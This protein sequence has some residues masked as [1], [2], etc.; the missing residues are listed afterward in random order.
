MYQ[1]VSTELA[2]FPQLSDAPLQS[3]LPPVAGLAV[4]VTH[5]QIYL[6]NHIFSH[7]FPSLTQDT[8]GVVGKLLLCAWQPPEL[9][10][11]GLGRQH[12]ESTGHEDT[13]PRAA[14][15]VLQNTEA[16]VS[17]TQP[18]V[19]SLCRGLSCQDKVLL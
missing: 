3:S 9:E 15:S 18:G 4:A 12:P 13:V 11:A 2:L 7:F 14:E 19:S 1:V 10:G 16:D 17:A 8:H 6:F 5:V